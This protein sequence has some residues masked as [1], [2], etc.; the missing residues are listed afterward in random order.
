MLEFV[1]ESDQT[2]H[3]G[4]DPGTAPIRSLN[5]ACNK[6]KLLDSLAQFLLGL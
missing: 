3:L 5:E 4:V 2:L 6:T 1:I